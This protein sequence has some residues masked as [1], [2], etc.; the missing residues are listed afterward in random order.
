MEFGQV[1]FIDLSRGAM[2]E[3]TVMMMMMMISVTFHQSC[4]VQYVKVSRLDGSVPSV[5]PNSISL[6]ENDCDSQQTR[7]CVGLEKQTG[8]IPKKSV[9]V[10]NSIELSKPLLSEVSVVCPKSQS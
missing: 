8:A 5:R 6:G 3:T 9:F 7:A 2:C 4:A 10:S 1:N